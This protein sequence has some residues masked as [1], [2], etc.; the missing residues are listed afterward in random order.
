MLCVGFAC[1]V[2]ST[3]IFYKRARIIYLVF[4]LM[5][6]DQI[7]SLIASQEISDIYGQMDW[8]FSYITFLWTTVFMVKLC[9]LAFFHT[10]LLS[11]SRALT[12]YYW[13]AVVVT[14]IAWIYLVLQQLITCP[15]FG[16]SS[17]KSLTSA[18]DT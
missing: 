2:A 10:L 15:Y 13:T 9:Y 14:L 3:A 6:G 8:S 4:A 18:L 17:C 1:L 12:R 11:M 5:G 7:A 16:S